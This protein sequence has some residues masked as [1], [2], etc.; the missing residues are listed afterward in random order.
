MWNATSADV[1]A[2]LVRRLRA[3]GGYTLI[4]L[5][6]VLGIFTIIVASLTQV[7]IS[8]SRAELDANRRFQAQQSARVA[9]D[10]MRRE[11][12]CASALTVNSASSVTITLGSG[13]PTSGGSQTTVTYDTSN[14]SASR[15]TIRRTKSGGSALVI[16]DYLTGGS[17]FSYTAP[18]FSTLGQL[19]VD[20]TVN[21]YPNEAWKK[22]R[23]VSDIVLRNTVRA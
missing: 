11:V 20:M 4:E 14:V 17:I 6:V 7:F 12:H 21:V 15:Y 3:R 19:H 18:S 23:L 10:R 13:C 5:V 9:I 2:R 1:I 22:W 8:G 16:G